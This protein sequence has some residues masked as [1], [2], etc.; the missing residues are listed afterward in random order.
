[1]TAE[2][3]VYKEDKEIAAILQIK[4]AYS[5]NDVNTI[6]SILNS[7]EKDPF[8]NKILDDFIR[9]IRLKAIEIKIKPYST[10]SL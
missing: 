4:D 7:I 3:Q 1:M 9:N 2:A 8:I 6:L 10:V 5:R